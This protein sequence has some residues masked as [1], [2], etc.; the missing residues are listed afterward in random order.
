MIGR[1]LTYETTPCPLDISIILK[2]GGKGMYGE[3]TKGNKINKTRTA[4]TEGEEKF[5]YL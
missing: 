3:V 5:K 4:K 1:E 2:K